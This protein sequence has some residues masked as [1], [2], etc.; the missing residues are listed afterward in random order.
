MVAVT[1][2]LGAALDTGDTDALAQREESGVD[3]GVPTE[4]RVK[5]GVKVGEDVCVEAAKHLQE[6]STPGTQQFARMS[7]GHSSELV[8]KV[9]AAELLRV[10]V[11]APEMLEQRLGARNSVALVDDVAATVHDERPL[12]LWLLEAEVEPDALNELP[13]ETR[14]GPHIPGSSRV[15]GV[16]V[17]LD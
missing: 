2:G 13:P 7:G 4:R 17:E 10:G 8:L 12:R 3:V 16:P 5:A 14:Y 1:D 9:A 15:K 11:E 6:S